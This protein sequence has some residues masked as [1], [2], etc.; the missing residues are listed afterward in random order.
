[1]ENVIERAVNMVTGTVILAE[2]I[3]FDHDFKFNTQQLPS[4]VLPSNCTLAEAC[5][6]VE[7]NML[8]QALTKYKT[9]RSLGRALGLS[10]TAVIRKMHKYGLE[11]PSK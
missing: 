11:F 1:M 10:H 5:A 2:H 7:Y 6:K 3:H 9:S 8:A 4:S